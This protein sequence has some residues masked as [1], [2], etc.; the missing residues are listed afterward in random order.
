M[1]VEP[2]INQATSF[3]DR[4]AA[5]KLLVADTGFSWPVVCDG[6]E[7]GFLSH[8]GA[9]PTRYYI[10]V[11]GVLAFKIQLSAGAAGRFDVHELHCWLEGHA[12]SV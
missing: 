7:N 1:G 9:W 10:V 5:A 2:A 8:F 3:E 11:D 4:A 6:M 12:A